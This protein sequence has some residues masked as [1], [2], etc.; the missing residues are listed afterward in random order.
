[1][2][3]LGEPDPNHPHHTPAPRTGKLPRILWLV[4]L[5]ALGALGYGA[6]GQMERRAQAEQT[7]TETAAFIPKVRAIQAR[8]VATP[9]QVTLPGATDAF[10]QSVV[11]ARATGYVAERNVDIG[12]RVKSGQLLARIEAPELRQQ[13]LQAEAQLAQTDAALDQAR[14]RVVQTRSDLELAQL[15]NRRTG[16]LADTGYASKQNADV[17]RLSF[18][19]RAADV[20]NATAGVEVAQ[21]NLRAQLATT[22]RLRQLIA[23]TRVTAPFDGVITSRSIETGDLINA[24]TGAVAMFTIMRDD[25]LRVRINVPQ[26]EA[27]GIVE[28]LRAVV[29]VPELPGQSFEGKVARSSVALS[30]ASRTLQVEVDVPNNERALRPG[31]Y[32]SVQIEVPRSAAVVIVPAE[33]L[34]FNGQGLQVLVAD[35]QGVVQQKPVKI[36][37]DFGQQVELASGLDGNEV[38]LLSAPA[39]MATGDRVTP[40]LPKETKQ[41]SAR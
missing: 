12:A 19:S 15:N 4:P 24:D 18:M 23:F 8:R 11:R 9:M 5:A 14:A 25:V 17:T 37:R 39:G 31:L 3:H 35:A 38:V 36:R 29:L 26:S 30:G 40:V 13:L 27:T 1:M 21:A 33:A 41:A 20:T 32:V 28:G 16:S 2:T 7:Q 10:E 34:V 22:N 6:M